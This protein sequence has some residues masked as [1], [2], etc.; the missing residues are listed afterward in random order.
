[1]QEINVLSYFKERGLEIYLE[2]ETL[3]VKPQSGITQEVRDFVRANKAEIISA[4]KSAP[5]DTP[6]AAVNETVPTEAVTEEPPRPGTIAG[7]LDAI[8]ER[9]IKEGKAELVEQLRHEYEERVSIIAEYSKISDE[10][11]QMLAARETVKR[12]LEGS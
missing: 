6:V 12:W 10:T 5:L 8:F 9:L 1:M 4:I 2:G 3:R 7:T 11:A